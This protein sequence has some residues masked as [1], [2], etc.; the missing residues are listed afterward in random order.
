MRELRGS[1]THGLHTEGLWHAEAE[2]LRTRSAIG[3]GWALLRECRHVADELHRHHT[4]L[5]LWWHPE[6]IG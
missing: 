6:G 4:L 1:V 3:L 5:L 2:T